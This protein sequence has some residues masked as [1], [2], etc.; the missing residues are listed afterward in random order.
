MTAQIPASN[1]PGSYTN[2]TRILNN[3]GNTLA[4]FKDTYGPQGE[5]IHRRYEV[6]GPARYVMPDGSVKYKGE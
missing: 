6:P 1:I 3:D 4:W 5:F 2:V